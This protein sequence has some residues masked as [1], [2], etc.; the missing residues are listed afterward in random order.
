LITVFGVT[1]LLG[2]IGGLM[3]IIAAR[4]IAASQVSNDEL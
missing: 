1:N 2:L 4:S 3:A